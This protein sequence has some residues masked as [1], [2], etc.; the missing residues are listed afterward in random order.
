MAVAPLIPTTNRRLLKF[1][2]EIERSL[3]RRYCGE[4]GLLEAMLGAGVCELEDVIKTGPKPVYTLHDTTPSVKLHVGWMV[5]MTDELICSKL[6][7]R[8]EDDRLLSLMLA[9]GLCKF[10]GNS[11]EV[12]VRTAEHGVLVVTLDGESRWISDVKVQIELQLGIPTSEQD[13]LKLVQGRCASVSDEAVLHQHCVLILYV[14]SAQEIMLE[15][16]EKHHPHYCLMGNFQRVRDLEINGRGV[17]RHTTRHH[18]FMYFANCWAWVVAD[19]EDKMRSGSDDCRMFSNEDVLTPDKI[20]IW[21]VHEGGDKFVHHEAVQTRL[22]S[23]AE[24]EEEARR[25]DNEQSLAL[26]QAHKKRRIVVEATNPIGMIRDVLGVYSLVEGVALD[27]R[28]VWVRV[29][30]LVTEWHSGQKSGVKGRQVGQRI[31]EDE[32]ILVLNW[33]VGDIPPGSG[34]RDCFFSQLKQDVSLALGGARALHPRRIEIVSIEPGSVVV[35]LRFEPAAAPEPV[36]PRKDFPAQVPAPTLAPAP[37]PVSRPARGG[38]APIISPSLSDSDKVVAMYS[39]AARRKEELSFDKG[40]GLIVIERTEA[41]PDGW[42]LAQGRQGRGL[43]P[44]NYRVPDG[45][46]DGP[47]G[48]FSTLEPRK[49][50]VK[51]AVPHETQQV[52]SNPEVQQREAMEPATT[53]SHTMPEE[54]VAPW[55]ALSPVEAV[56]E[57][58]KQLS[59]PGSKIFRGQITFAVDAPRSRDAMATPGQSVA[60][61]AGPSGTVQRED[62]NGARKGATDESLIIH[63]NGTRREW[64]ISEPKDVRCSQSLGFS[65]HS[66]TAGLMRASALLDLGGSTADMSAL[67]PADVNQPWHLADGNGGW[68][69]AAGVRVREWDDALDLPSSPKSE[70][71]LVEQPHNT[72]QPRTVQTAV[73]HS[74]SVDAEIHKKMK[75]SLRDEFQDREK[76]RYDGY[77][78]FCCGPLLRGMRSA[79]LQKLRAMAKRD[80][81]KGVQPRT[82]LEKHFGGEVAIEKSFM[83]DLFY[84]LFQ[85]DKVLSMFFCDPNHPFTKTERRKV[86]FAMAALALVLLT[87]IKP[88]TNC[89]DYL[90]SNSNTYASQRSRFRFDPGGVYYYICENADRMSD[91]FRNYVFIIFITL[92]KTMYGTYLENISFCPC[93]LRYDNFSYGSINKGVPPQMVHPLAGCPL[94]SESEGFQKDDKVQ[95]DDGEKGTRKPAKVRSRKLAERSKQKAE[96]DKNSGADG[97]KLNIVGYDVRYRGK[98]R[99]MSKRFLESLGGA[100]L[101][102]AVVIGLASLS[103]ACACIYYTSP[104]EREQMVGGF[105]T[106]LAIGVVMGPISLSAKFWAQYVHHKGIGGYRRGM[107]SWWRDADTD[108]SGSTGVC[109]ICNAIGRAASHEA[110]H[111]TNIAAG[112]DGGLI[113]LVSFAIS[114]KTEAKKARARGRWHKAQLAVAFSTSWRGK[115]RVAPGGGQAAA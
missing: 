62:E 82:K 100:L 28:A 27:R 2:P 5:N 80:G 109:E 63:F 1:A 87:S 67:T 9:R 105:V 61:K 111:G 83:E 69:K 49:E 53:A 72:E 64:Y 70:E 112:E 33:R 11:F 85:K 113:A 115:S 15:G 114:P 90:D 31:A 36:P 32:A 78:Y 75:L 106:S 35:Q 10:V 38:G 8:C 104:D 103:I 98:Q 48:T 26:L 93:L 44:S 6:G 59:T 22:C 20:K 47:D 51:G 4:R 81:P 30:D 14:A 74:E 66:G 40:E 37:P 17:W 19:G 21:H 57:L 65:E 97:E 86:Y 46:N 108:M 77:F 58:Q 39:Y 79:N 95:V 84:F 73:E 60:S 76:S 18:T 92:L 91:T 34:M 13:L 52:T 71:R 41:N 55:E 3:R 25:L 50:E 56:V 54:P 110:G 94:P 89:E 42:W 7:T 96:A 107:K 23:A 68:V 29:T 24:S 43:F 88:P 99:K 102:V 45:P 16:L 12:N 101:D